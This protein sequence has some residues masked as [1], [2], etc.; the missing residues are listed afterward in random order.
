MK[1]AEVAQLLE[2]TAPLSYQENYDNAGLLTGDADQTCTGILCTLDATEAVI[3]EARRRNCNLVI[4]HHPII[5]GGLKKITGRNYVE[6]TVIN[7]IKNDIAIYAIHTNLDNVIKGVNDKIAD[8]LE[9]INR[10][11][12]A[13]KTAQLMKL[14]TFAPIEFAERVR[15]AIFEAGAG[16]VGNYSECSFNAEGTGTFKAEEGTKPFVGEI[17]KRREEREI[18]M[19]FIFPAY[20]QRQIVSAMIKAHPYEEVAF[21]IVVLANEDLQIGSGLV[22]ELS[23]PITEEQFLQQVKKTFGL[24][25]I[26]H[27]KLQD[28]PIKKVALCGGAGS[29]LISKAIAVNA[30]IYITSDVK[31]H[32]FFDANEKIVIADIGHW[33]SEQ[34]TVDLLFDI[35]KVKFP[36]FAVLKS[37]E[38][39]N[40]VYYFT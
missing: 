20:L 35:I 24:S 7:A 34:F 11:I 1:I 21:D 26:K 12:L 27:T 37:E 38:R 4:A 2:K 5:F 9:L 40:P 8:K 36:T 32:E 16:H 3:Y 25:V 29:F 30:D 6:S 17:G 31:Y 15:S 13:P 33:E 10:K 22:G 23:T 39:T 28:K 14:F 18:K 19:E